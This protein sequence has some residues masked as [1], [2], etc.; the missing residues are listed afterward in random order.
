MAGVRRILLIGILLSVGLHNPSSFAIVI[1]DLGFDV[2][3]Q[4]VDGILSGGLNHEFG[5]TISYN[6]G[7][8]EAA[9]YSIS[10]DIRLVGVDPGSTV[11]QL[12]ETDTERIWSTA[13]RFDKPVVVDVRFVDQNPNQV[14]TVH[15]GPGRGDVQNW[16]VGWPSGTG[17]PA[18]WAHEVGHF[19]GNYDEYPGG[20]V[21]PNGSFMN[22]SDSIMG[23]G[24]TVYDRQYSFIADW[25]AGFASAP[26]PAS[27]LIM[28][29][30]VL[31][32]ALAALARGR[33][34]TK[35]QV[36]VLLWS[37]IQRA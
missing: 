5:G 28:S 14:V 18:P 6:I 34:R 37:P 8:T 3:V 16:Y 12:W 36:V 26:E 30:P 25:A 19:F 21:N 7:F 17:S 33:R 9:G 35:P 32:L 11:K 24:S 23:T 20:A 1:P 4:R 10:E 31:L 15:P 13:D 27:L 29:A 22:V 2:P